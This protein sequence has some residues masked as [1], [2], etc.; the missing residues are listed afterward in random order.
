[1]LPKIG[2]FILF[3]VFLLSQTQTLRSQNINQPENVSNDWKLT[4]VGKVKQLVVN[5]GRL[6]SW[7]VDYPGLIDCEYPAGSKEEHISRCLYQLSGITEDGQKVMNGPDDLWPSSEPWD[8]IWVVNSGEVVHI[9][10]WPNYTPV[11]DQDFVARYDDYTILDRGG[12]EPHI[13]LNVDVIQTVFSWAGPPPLDEVILWTY[14]IIPRQFDLTGVYFTITNE[15]TIGTWTL[16]PAADDR[17]SYYPDLNME[18]FEDGPGGED[19]DAIG[20]L[21][22]QFFFPSDYP[23]D[24]YKPTW[25]WG[26]NY[27]DIPGDAIERIRYERVV[28]SGMIMQNQQS[29]DGNSAWFSVGP[30]KVDFG[31]TLIIR[32]AEILGEGVDG[33]LNNAEQFATL[34]EEM[35]VDFKVPSSPPP[36]PLRAETRS[37]EIRLIWEPT[38]QIN[39]EIYRDPNRADSVDQP[40]EGYRVYKSTQ[41]LEGPW[42]LLAEYDVLNNG[43]GNNFGLAYEY[44]DLGLLNNTEYYYAVT[45]FCKS[46]T[47]LGW[48]ELESS[49]SQSSI[50]AIPGSATP[51]TVGKVAAVPN[52][53]RGDIDYHS[54]IPPWEPSPLERSWLEQDR[55]IQ[56]INLPTRCE[57]NIHTLAGDFVAG[58]EHNDPVRGFENWNLTSD[59]G[60]AVASGLYFFTVKDL[61]NGKVQVGKLVVIK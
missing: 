18:V 2:S 32:M 51:E 37:K 1:M 13:P 34:V 45:S 6:Y 28:A 33:V 10:Y 26:I 3:L 17:V 20:A 49:F 57:I 50:V 4:T 11:S 43:Y 9:P 39:P 38:T 16:N 29:Y 58:I 8:T 30:F 42:V 53:Y 44:T 21:G 5:R 40:F 36:P 7:N 56:F 12:N 59:Q 46:D 61:Q 54:Y 48:P 14:Y 22:F 60:Q 52:P 55:R 15:S 47:V 31:D 27:F 35:G 23:E 25:L 24:Q 41:S 19:G